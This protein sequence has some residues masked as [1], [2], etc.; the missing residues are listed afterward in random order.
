MSLLADVAASLRGGLVEAVAGGVSGGITILAV[1]PI[2]SVQTFQAAGSMPAGSSML[3][4]MRH[5]YA[6][7]GPT[8]FFKGWIASSSTVF[9]EKFWLFFW[10]SILQATHRSVNQVSTIGAVALT[11]CGWAA[12]NMAIPT[13][14]P[15]EVIL[16]DQQTSLKTEGFTAT[17]R[18]IWSTQGVPGFYK[19]WN[20]YLLYGFRSGIQQSLFD[21]F[22][23]MR[24]RQLGAQGVV[25]TE[26]SFGTAFLLGA[27]GRFIS[28]L[29]T[30]PLLRAKIMAMSEEGAE[31]GVIGSLQ[32]CWDTGGGFLGMYQGLWAEMCRS[33]CFQALLMGTKEKLDSRVAGLL[34]GAAADQV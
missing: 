17:A 19:G 20:V 21:V 26:L 24:I 12:E 3:Q 13:R 32:R 8:R 23:S 16:R 2:E 33:I 7:G 28:T 31:L 22:K 6:S 4:T 1:L 5:L 15:V 29:G 30:Y 25:V 9:T 34:I 10:Y 14:Y 11:I 18:R 27:V